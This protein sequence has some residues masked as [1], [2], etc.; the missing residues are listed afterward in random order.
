VV[1]KDKGDNESNE[2]LMRGFSRAVRSLGFLKQKKKSRFLEP[3]PNKR[4]V[5]TDALRRAKKTAEREYLIKI[6]KIEERPQY[7]SQRNAPKKDK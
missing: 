3:K 5:R 1:K 6:G 7:G 4:K 2:S